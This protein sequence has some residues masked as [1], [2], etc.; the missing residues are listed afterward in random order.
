MNPRKKLAVIFAAV[1]LSL[2]MTSSVITTASAAPVSCVYD[3]ALSSPAGYNE[4][5]GHVAVL[6]LSA[7]TR[8]VSITAKAAN[9]GTCDVPATGTWQVGA[10]SAF[11]AILTAE[12]TFPSLTDSSVLIEVPEDNSFAKTAS[13]T[14]STKTTVEGASWVPQNTA[15]LTLKRRTVWSTT[16]ATPEPVAKWGDLTVRAI[17]TRADWND[18]EYAAFSGRT[19]RLQARAVGGVWNDT[20]LLDTDVTDAS[21]KALLTYSPNSDAVYRLH[22][23][24][25]KTAGHSDAYGDTVR[26]KK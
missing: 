1:A 3:Y 15:P 10:P 9:G 6:G 25:N 24:G 23:G 12:G 22:Y 7:V 20:A 13:V 11:G 26:L 19:V 21:G 14:I 2:G 8:S 4:T 16:N 17:L 5:S 18:G